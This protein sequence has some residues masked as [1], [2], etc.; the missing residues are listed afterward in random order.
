MFHQTQGL[1]QRSLSS[2]AAALLQTMSWLG[3]VRQLRNV[4]ERVLI[5]G[6][7]ADEIEAIRKDIS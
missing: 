7:D 5:L 6:D 2:E 4:I 1:P 3:N